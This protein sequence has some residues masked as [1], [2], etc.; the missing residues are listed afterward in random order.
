MPKPFDSLK[1]FTVP[2]F[3][4]EAV[5][6]LVTTISET[7]GV[8]LSRSAEPPIGEEMPRP[9]PCWK[10]IAS[11]TL[12]AELS[13]SFEPPI[14]EEIPRPTHHWNR[15][16]SETLGAELF[17]SPRAPRATAMTRRPL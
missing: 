9:I 17:R 11:E 6:R 8:E 3:F 1:N 12:G 4:W 10:L 13:R 2:V 14:G 15:I 16:N 5:P 7:L